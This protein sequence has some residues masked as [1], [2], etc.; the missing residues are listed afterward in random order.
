MDAT[1]GSKRDR[2]ICPPTQ[3]PALTVS[4]G[5]T[6]TDLRVCGA[7]APRA[8]VAAAPWCHDTLSGTEQ[9]QGQPRHRKP[10]NSSA[11]EAIRIPNTASGQ[12]PRHLNKPAP[13]PAPWIPSKFWKT[14]SQSQTQEW[15]AR[16]E[17]RGCPG[18]SPVITGA[19]KVLL[20]HPCH[21]HSPQ[22]FRRCAGHP[23]KTQDQKQKSC[24]PKHSLVSAIT[25]VGIFLIRYE[26]L[27]YSFSYVLFLPLLNV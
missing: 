1:S 17:S 11:A 6:E 23:L 13:S 9:G 12:P 20:P 27:G 24:A 26:H 22:H 19:R 21:G 18:L 7:S 15:K 25:G 4:D 10:P 8:G 5:H 3:P 16:T 2:G 14:S